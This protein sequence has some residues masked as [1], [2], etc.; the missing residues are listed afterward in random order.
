MISEYRHYDKCEEYIQH[1]TVKIKHILHT[2]NIGMSVHIANT[3][4]RIPT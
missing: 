2:T 1:D 4:V 3:Y